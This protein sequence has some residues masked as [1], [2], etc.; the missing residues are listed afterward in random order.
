MHLVRFFTQITSTTTYSK[1]ILTKTGNSDYTLY[2][3]L[4]LLATLVASTFFTTS[5]EI[6]KK[7]TILKLS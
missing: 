2:F 7:F 5:L 3:A 4:E 1:K 6:P